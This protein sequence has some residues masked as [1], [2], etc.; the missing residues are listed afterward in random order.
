M[1][2]PGTPWKDCS[3]ASLSSDIQS[4]IG[5]LAKAKIVMGA[6]AKQFQIAYKEK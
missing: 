3:P 5:R 1:P 6:F 4:E 2:L